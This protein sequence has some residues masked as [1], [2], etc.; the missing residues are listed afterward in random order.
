MEARR[1][2]DRAA[3]HGMPMAQCNAKAMKTTND[4]AGAKRRRAGLSSGSVSSLKPVKNQ[5]SS[6]MQAA[7]VRATPWS[8]PRSN[9]CCS[10]RLLYASP[11]LKDRCDRP[12]R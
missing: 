8:V 1:V 4:R 9:N 7:T 11:G 5:N 6:A 12:F 2:K 10:I 3:Y